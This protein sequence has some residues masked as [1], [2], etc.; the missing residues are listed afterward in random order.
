M[1]LLRQRSF[2]FLILFVL[3]TLALI[4]A[5][6]L[7]WKPRELPVY[8]EIRDFRLTERSGR[9]VTQQDLDGKIWIADFIF[10]RCGGICPMMSA[11]MRA[12]QEKLKHYP[13]VRFVS[14]SVDPEYDTPEVLT[15]Y[16]Q[17]FSA[18]PQKWLFLTGDK[19]QLFNLS[20]QHF[21]LGVGEIPPAEREAPD[22]SV[23]HSSKFALVDAEG[24]IR[25]YYASEDAGFL[26]QLARDV[27]HLFY[28]R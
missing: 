16:A 24:K 15:K 28:R 12:V 4:A 5:G 20:S 27:N 3:T 14:F 23:D 7:H 25:G 8:G 13:D 6:T 2:W 10:T 21:H 1:A 18:D 19:Q 9:T 11:K 26:D 22:Q 17:H